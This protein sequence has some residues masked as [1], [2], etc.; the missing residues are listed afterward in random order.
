VVIF[1]T[2]IDIMATLLVLPLLS[3][4]HWKTVVTANHEG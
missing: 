1:G 4:A 3:G 2:L